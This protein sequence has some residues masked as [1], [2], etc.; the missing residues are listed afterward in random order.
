MANEITS[1]TNDIGKGV[2][3]LVLSLEK[4]GV[5]RFANVGYRLAHVFVLK[6]TI[7][8]S[9]EVT[10]FLMWTTLIEVQ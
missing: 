1:V 6:I 3:S 2:V 8:T 9:S 4:I 10:I 7:I 5:L